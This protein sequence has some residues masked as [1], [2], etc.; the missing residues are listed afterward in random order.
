MNPSDQSDI[1]LM[2]AVARR[3]SAALELLYD[4]YAPNALGLAVKILGDRALAEDV[5]QE[6]FLRVWK[7][8]ATFDASR[9]QFPG[10]LFGI[11]RNLAIDEYRRRGGH[12]LVSIDDGEGSESLV[13]GDGAADVPATV[14]DHWEQERVQDALRQLPDAQRQVIL[15]AYFQGYTRQ[16]IAKKLGQ[17][18]GTI[19]TRARLALQKLKA[20]LSVQEQR[21]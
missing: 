7:S 3:E 9:G 14:A 5:L 12:T 6:A 15:L 18:P 20:I 10:W 21:D 13:S 2:S 1:E 19:H 4:R 17:P 8:A 16:E 11:V